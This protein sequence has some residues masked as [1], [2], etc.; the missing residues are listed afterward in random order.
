MK[1]VSELTRE[2]LEEIAV[3][4]RDILWQDP[5]T[6]ELDPGRSWCVETLER[7]SGV[8]EDAGLKPG[9]DTAAAPAGDPDRIDPGDADRA[10]RAAPGRA[11]MVEEPEDDR[12]LLEIIPAALAGYPGTTASLADGSALDV[13]L[14][15]GDA[16]RITLDGLGEDEGDPIGGGPM[17]AGY[18]RPDRIAD[19]ATLLDAVLH[20]L[21]GSPLRGHI[22]GL[23]TDGDGDDCEAMFRL[24]GAPVVLKVR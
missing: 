22:T 17:S 21:A 24:R 7:V 10:A 5:V 3:R 12:S 6:G 4:I 1:Q 16:Y 15:D 14:A 20:A 2:Q 19:H 13:R 9:A 23:T 11:P 8:I 18:R